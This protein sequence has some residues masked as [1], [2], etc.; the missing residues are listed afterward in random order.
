MP[1]C[2]SVVVFQHVESGKRVRLSSRHTTT[3]PKRW[4]S[5]SLVPNVWLSLPSRLVKSSSSRSTSMLTSIKDAGTT[6]FVPGTS[7]VLTRL[8]SRVIPEQMS[9]LHSRRL[10][11]W[12][13]PLPPPLLLLPLLP[14][15]LLVL[16][17][18]SLL[19]RIMVAVPTTCLS[20]RGYEIK[21][22]G[23][24]VEPLPIFF[25]LLCSSFLASLLLFLQ[26]CSSS[27]KSLCFTSS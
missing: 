26:V 16:R 7:S 4:C 22:N 19:L 21:D 11:Q 12:V 3:S 14:L 27:G 8:L 24:R 13:V 23:K 1:C 25:V 17:L 18:H 20:K 6:A 9:T 15:P 5:M 10:P 2:P